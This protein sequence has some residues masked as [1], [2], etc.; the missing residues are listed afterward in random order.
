MCGLPAVE[1]RYS[2]RNAICPDYFIDE[3]DIIISNNLKFNDSSR[4]LVK[5]CVQKCPWKSNLMKIE[6]SYEAF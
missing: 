4:Q 5:F 6:G 2:L 1:F 3:F